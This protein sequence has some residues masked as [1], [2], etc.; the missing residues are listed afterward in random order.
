MGASNERWNTL[1]WKKNDIWELVILPSDY[2]AFEVKWC[3]MWRKNAK[4]K[5]KRYKVKLIVKGYKQK[6]AV[7]YKEVVAL[8][9][10]L[11]TI[12]LL[13]AL[14]AQN[15]LSTHQMNVKS[16]LLNDTLEEKN[17]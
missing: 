1:N 3:I 10:R 12:W 11:E 17:I 8:V 4:D 15:R 5:V 13:V 14:A 7:D 6:H 2:Q 16:I 9:A